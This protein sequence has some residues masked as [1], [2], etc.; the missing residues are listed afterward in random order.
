MPKKLSP[1][2][3]LLSALLREWYLHGDDPRLLV[4]MDR[5]VELGDDPTVLLQAKD[6]GLN[7]GSLRN[8]D[9]PA[10]LLA[11]R[12]AWLVGRTGL[13]SRPIE[14]YA[15]KE[16]YHGDRPHLAAEKALAE[17]F[18]DHVL[19][20]S[21]DY[22]FEYADEDE[23]EN[24]LPG[25]VVPCAVYADTGR[26]PE[27]WSAIES[28]SGSVLLLD[29]PEYTWVGGRYEEQHDAGKYDWLLTDPDSDSYVGRRFGMWG[30]ES[31]EN[32][33]DM[34]IAQRLVRGARPH[35]A[36][37][38]TNF[39][40]LIRIAEEIPFFGKPPKKKA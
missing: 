7:V 33:R 23:D 39:Q 2:A 1:E 3:R 38:V 4:L 25:Q 32:N 31:Y 37:F 19:G 15:G 5:L 34:E 12:F 40:N 18:A 36:R 27:P 9:D 8:R 22:D 28:P 6:L 20:W 17:W 14:G 16:F 21:V 26:G 35:F 11:N 24:T 29:D 30:E 10:V 13:F